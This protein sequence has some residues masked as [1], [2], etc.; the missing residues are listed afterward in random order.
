VH[1]GEYLIYPRTV[2]WIADGRLEIDAGR[3]LLD[4]EVLSAPVRIQGAP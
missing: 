1:E 2:A 3:V 4:G